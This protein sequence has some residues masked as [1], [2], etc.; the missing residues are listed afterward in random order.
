M[1]NLG[2]AGRGMVLIWSHEFS[3]TTTLSWKTQLNTTFSALGG[4]INWGG[5]RRKWKERKDEWSRWRHDGEDICGRQVYVSIPD[6][7]KR[8]SHVLNGS[9]P[10]CLINHKK[11]DFPF[12]YVRRELSSVLGER[13]FCVWLDF[14]LISG[15]LFF[16]FTGLVRN[17]YFK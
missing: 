6:W 17:V 10:R 13:S 2:V 12:L 3:K 5:S 14:A 7:V 8:Q 15:D 1:R 9:F 16:C 11:K 4:W